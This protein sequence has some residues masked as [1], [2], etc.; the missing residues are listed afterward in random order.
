MISVRE[1]YMWYSVIAKKLIWRFEIVMSIWK[2][3]G[4]LQHI[5][6]FEY[7]DTTL[8]ENGDFIYIC[9][10]IIW[11]FTTSYYHRYYSLN[12]K[13]LIHD[14]RNTGLKNYGRWCQNERFRKQIEHNMTLWL[15]P[16]ECNNYWFD[17]IWFPLSAA[18]FQ[19]QK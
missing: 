11:F 3:Y 12:W 13:K 4:L 16:I 6:Q 10:W 18:P 2:G 1:L 8:W 14:S 9:S 19:Q 15:D 17:L 5:S 7:S